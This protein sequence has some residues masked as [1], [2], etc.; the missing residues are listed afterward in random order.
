METMQLA[1]ELARGALLIGL[2]LALPF[3]L[4]ALA[5]GLIVSVLQ[6]MTQV[7]DPVVSQVPKLLAVGGALVVLGSWCLKVTCG[8][9]QEIFGQLGSALVP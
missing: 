4:L 3:L 1:T 7:Q 8:Y 2:K 5:V 6:A 9:A